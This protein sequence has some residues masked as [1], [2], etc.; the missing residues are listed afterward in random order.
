METNEKGFGS[1][2]QNLAGDITALVR[3]EMRLAQAETSE[4]VNQ[5]LMAAV[6][7]V[8]GLLVAFAALILLLEGVSVAL[9]N[10]MPA[11]VAVLLVGVVTAAIALILISKGKN[12]LSTAR[13]APQRTMRNVREDAE[14][15]RGQAR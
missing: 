14:L 11:W 12:D 4:K 10:F 13:L 7:I 9:A 8:A 15:A 6:S 2:L 5:V 1:L 3:D